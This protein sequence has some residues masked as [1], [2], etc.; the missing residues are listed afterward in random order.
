MDLLKK[1]ADEKLGV[2]EEVSEFE[3]VASDK[4]SGPASSSAGAAAA[5]ASTATNASSTQQPTSAG[6]VATP[7][8]SIFNTPRNATPAPFFSPAVGARPAP[9]LPRGLS[10]N[11]LQAKL[12]HLRARQTTL[13]E[14]ASSLVG[15]RRE[16]IE[17]QI[18]LI[19]EQKAQLKKA[20]KQV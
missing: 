11:E 5:A 20:I 3:T 1:K 14:S 12:N 2:V 18:R 6:D 16:E 17:H 9:G 4:S 15:A 8:V 19:D 7:P 10:K 13:R